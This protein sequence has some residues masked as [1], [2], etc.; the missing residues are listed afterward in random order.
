MQNK[1][2][3]PAVPALTLAAL[4]VVFGDIGTSP[5]YALK[6]SFH[7][8]RGLPINEINVLGI[9]SLIFWTITLIVS[10]KYVLVIMRADNNGEGGIMAL[11]ALNL[12]Q[13][14][15]SSRKKFI[16]II[17][18]F[19]GASLFFGDG[20]IT[21]AISVLS[22][23]EGLSIATPAFDRF[24]IPISIGILVALFAVQRHGS[25][26]M[27]KFFGPITL[28]WFLSIGAIGISSIIQ[29]P[30]VLALLSPHWAFLF[31][32]N[33]P[34]ISF[35]VMGAV[36]LTVTGGEALYADMGH[37]GILPIRL[38]WFLIVL[39][40]LILNYAGQGAL[41]LRD[42]SAITNP[43]YLLL[44]S[45][46]LYPMIILAT[47]AAV[48][49]SQA[50]ISGVFSMAKQAIQL[51]YL[52]RL[53]ILHTSD[54]EIGQIY[55]PL[56]NWLLF[57][58]IT[59]LV[60]IF[61]NSSSLAGAYGLAVTVTMFCDTLLVAFLA[62][63]YWK[64]QTWKVLLFIIP[65]V[66]ID[67]ILLSSNLLKVFIGGWVPVFIAIIVFTLM[68]TWK[69]GR[70]ILQEKLQKDTLA[71]N[72][73]IQYMGDTNQRISGNA[74][75][76][77][78]TPQ[79]VP[80]ALLHNLKHNKV[81]HERNL[82][83]TISIMEVPYVDAENRIETEVLDKGFYR[84]RL[85]YGFKE[86]PDVPKALEKAFDTLRLEY[87]LMDIS[88]FVSRERLIPSMSNKMSNWREKLF[89]T[90]QKN[91]SPVSDFYKIPSN[92]VVELGSQIEI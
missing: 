82:L 47:A 79:V 41:L 75:F 38:G 88:F 62:Y 65:F 51:G 17:L 69:K 49:A 76:L 13:K 22:A 11:L 39:P 10:I 89:V 48:I 4:G 9:L 44:P 35:F 18:G 45:A 1:V 74:V 78:G 72:T 55:I 37:F 2:S 63:S 15:L 20:I 6:E 57:I 81:L 36:V 71:L 53:T 80:H 66:F 28:I 77:T 92:R 7:A 54:S 84:I 21:P 16:I 85:N 19:V 50:L 14:G 33:N 5:L 34:F 40:C 25:A 73:F 60:L 87:N 30:F 42:P 31:V 91:T 43:F 83:V 64:W 70:E 67:L 56:L 46:L 8:T 90:M 59:I 61:E 27:G 86:E 24:I 52:P 58:S 23:V 29:S 12:R 26:V 3:K 32:V 68:M